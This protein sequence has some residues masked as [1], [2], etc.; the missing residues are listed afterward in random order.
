[1]R[2]DK[3][4]CQRNGLRENHCRSQTGDQL[5]RSRYINH[6]EE[7]MAPIS[8][9]EIGVALRNTACTPPPN[10]LTLKCVNLGQNG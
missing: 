8:K 9:H 1:M 4:N 7:V 3:I 5:V 6:F 2:L 10:I